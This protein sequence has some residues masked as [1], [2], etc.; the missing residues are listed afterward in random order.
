MKVTEF[1]VLKSVTHD[2]QGWVTITSKNGHVVQMKK[3]YAGWLSVYLKAQKM[4]GRRI[5]YETGVSGS[6]ADYF[7]DIHEDNLIA[8]CSYFL[9]MQDRQHK[10]N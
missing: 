10:P 9:T 6:A 8:R 7:R 4:I 3:T 2:D 5:V 1:G